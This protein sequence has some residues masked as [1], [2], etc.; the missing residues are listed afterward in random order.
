MARKTKNSHGQRI[1]GL[2]LPRKDE[3]LRPLWKAFEKGSTWHRNG[4]RR[5]E[6][7]RL[8]HTAYRG[9]VRLEWWGDAIRYVIDDADKSGKIGGAFLGHAQRHGGTS[10][11]RLEVRFSRD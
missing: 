4:R 8:K 3:D 9:K 11:D 5:K 2:I 6:S 7:L 1:E 10:I